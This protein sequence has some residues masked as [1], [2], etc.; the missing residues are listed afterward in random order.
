MA[1]NA[2][3]LGSGIMFAVTCCLYAGASS[4]VG[5]AGGT[6]E[7]TDPYRIAT[8]EQLLSIDSDPNLLDKCFVLVT[9][10]DLDPNLPGGRVFTQAVIAPNLDDNEVDFQGAVF[11]GRFDG[12]GHTIRNL[13]IDTGSNFPSGHY[14]GLFGKVGRQAV[15]KNL[16]IETDNVGQHGAYRGALAGWNEGCV[17]D[18][19]ARGFM[20]AGTGMN[21][22]L[23][24]YN[25]G[26]IVR[27]RADFEWI[28]GY[29]EIGGLVGHN[30][31]GGRIIGC[32]GATSKI[33]LVNAYAGGLV[34]VNRGSI[35]SSCAAGSIYSLNKARVVGGLV[36][37]VYRDADISNCL[38]TVNV[39]VSRQASCLG[40]LVGLMGGAA[41]I[42]NCFAT[43]S[44][45]GGDMS[46][47]LGGL[48]GSMGY[49]SIRHCYA[50][51]QV[52]AGKDSTK[53]GGLIGSNEGSESKVE[54]SFWD[55]ETSGLSQSV[56]GIGLATFKMQDSHTYEAAGWDL[57]GEQANGVADLWF[58]P[59][60]GGYPTLSLP[61]GACDPSRYAGR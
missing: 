42:S 8:A 52:H 36:G 31:A 41:S 49:A 21:G 58:I 23:V 16:G 5:L 45:S 12:D 18:C 59:K 20:I 17:L 40:G 28:K 43:G 35:T 22:G 1:S 60:S 6:G 32:S 11:A 46:T 26:D 56:G 2:I 51:G 3:V 30:A 37:E 29:E 15:V 47:A 54:A 4:A 39:S 38:A 33:G 10:I 61:S 27:S 14:V 57:V 7:L 24:G 13:K 44:V 50:I 34:G 9:D 25:D 53:I 19:H 55:T 48:I